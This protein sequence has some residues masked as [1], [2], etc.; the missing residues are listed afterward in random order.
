MQLKLFLLLIASIIAFNL[1]SSDPSD[2]INKTQWLAAYS[3]AQ[4]KVFDHT[5]VMHPI[6]KKK[7]GTLVAIP[8]ITLSYPNILQEPDTS[9]G[10]TA[11]TADR[12]LGSS[13][14]RPPIVV[15]NASTA[16]T[17]VAPC[18]E[19]PP[20]NPGA[21]N[22]LTARVEPPTLPGITTTSAASRQN[23]E[24]LLRGGSRRRELPQSESHDH[25]THQRT[26]KR[27]RFV[28]SLKDFL[29]YIFGCR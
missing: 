28:D 5:N 24:L 29:S 22:T 11:T 20:L 8:L 23:P 14:S 21:L 17:A 10:A 25:F 2:G 18:G 6:N 4:E 7:P 9:A 3:H 13:I 26:Q 12:D 16:T 19:I 27:G 15:A 1:Y